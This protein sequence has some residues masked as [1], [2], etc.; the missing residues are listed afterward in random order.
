ML[1]TEFTRTRV[2][3][4][5]VHGLDLAK[6]LDREPWMTAPAAQVTGELLLPSPDAA[7][8]L[9]T[10]ASWDQVTLIAKLTGRATT[11][12]AETKLIQSLGTQRLALG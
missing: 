3:E 9:R 12:A 7:A 5:A 2:L 1:L 10:T 6:A 4:L 8:E 11:T